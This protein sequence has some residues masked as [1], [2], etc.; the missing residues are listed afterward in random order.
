MLS[1]TARRWY[2]TIGQFSIIRL[3][4]PTQLIVPVYDYGLPE[5]EC[6]GNSEGDPC[7]LFSRIPFPVEE[8][9]PPN[10]VDS[11]E[12]YRDMV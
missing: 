10:S 7:E 4:R 2:A 3:E 5:K 8:F 9:F 11:S 1:D 6:P 12:A